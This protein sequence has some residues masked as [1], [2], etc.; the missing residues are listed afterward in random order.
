M[1]RWPGIMAATSATLL[2]ALLN[3]PAPAE[4][5]D[6][7]P[8]EEIQTQWTVGAKVAKII[9]P[10]R[11]RRS[12]VAFQ[13]KTGSGTIRL[14]GRDIQ[15]ALEA[16]SGGLVLRLDVDAD[17]KASSRE[18]FVIPYRKKQALLRIRTG[19]GENNPIYSIV[20]DGIRTFGNPRESLTLQA[21]LYPA[22]G[23][24]ASFQNQDILLIDANLDGTYTQDGSDAIAIG[25]SAFAQPLETVHRIAGKPWRVKVAE[26]GTSLTLQPETT[27][28]SAPVE[29]PETLSPDLLKALI[30]RSAEGVVFD[31]ADSRS[32][33]AGEYTMVYGAMG[34][35]RAMAFCQPDGR[36]RYTIKPDMVNVP[37]IGPPV[38]WQV[39]ASMRGEKIMIF[40]PSQ[41]IGV[42]GERYNFPTA[43]GRNARIKFTGGGKLLLSKSFEHG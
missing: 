39:R 10:A 5:K 3:A 40:P 34:N 41:V 37:R 25:T 31:L 42:G 29:L 26:G 32:L 9:T 15:Y 11:A 20:L 17:G 24:S 7:A 36:A 16:A 23:Y 22:A 8:R 14:L 6:S 21:T 4:E 27:A 28:D 2:C 18:R 35:G 13:V 38:S 1:T 33:P 19:P 12:G 43:M 30:F